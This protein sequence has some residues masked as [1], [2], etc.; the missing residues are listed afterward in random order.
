MEGER[1]KR[2]CEGRKEGRSEGIY[3]VVMGVVRHQP[4]P[5]LATIWPVSA[6][7]RGAE[8]TALCVWANNW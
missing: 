4:L 8:V 2:Q 3:V 1:T 5:H 7:A 6:I